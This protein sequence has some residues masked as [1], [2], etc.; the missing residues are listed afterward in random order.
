VLVEIFN[1]HEMFSG[2]TIALPDLHTIGASTG[3]IVAMVSPNS[4]TLRQPFNWARVLHHEMVHVFNLEQTSF[5]CPHWF[6]EGLAV[7]AEGYPRPGAWNDLLKQRFAANNLLDLDT[8][9]LGF[10]RPRTQLEWNLAYCQSQL[11]IQYIRETYGPKAIAEMLAAYGSGLETAAAIQKVCQVPKAEFEKGYKKYLQ[12]VVEGLHGKISEKIFT[13]SQLLQEHDDHPEDLEISSQLAEQFLLRRD[14]VEARKLVE[15]VLAKK[16]EQPLAAYVKA[17]L[18]LDAGDEEPAKALLEKAL[19][20][21]NP[22]AKIVQLLGKLYYEAK[23]FDK[24]AELYEIES[25]IEPSETRWLIELG[26]SYTQLGKKDRL[27]EVLEKLTLADPD[28]IAQRK[29][30]AGML[31]E[32]GRMPQAERYAR[33]ALEIDVRDK[34]ARS[35]LE[36]A[37]TAQKKTAELEELKKI[38]D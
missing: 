3:R 4:K 14:R 20:R 9:D 38:L 13:Y 16:P 6:T 19:D 28:D 34:T 25:K 23:A 35:I 8:I 1:S 37:L 12:K 2:R 11:Y 22:N 29:K 33:E 21:N 18:L 24:A 7:I 5:Q 31:L 27:I 17:R 30:L 10:I 15:A 36:K 32:D 26:R